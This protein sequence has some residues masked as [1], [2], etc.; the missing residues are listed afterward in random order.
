MRKQ[1]IHLFAYSCDDC[2]GPVVSASLAIR[3]NAISRETDIRQVGAICLS[4]GHRQQ[5]A[6]AT[7]AVRHFPPMEWEPADATG[8]AS[9]TTAL[10]EA[11]GRVEPR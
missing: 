10:V 4:C 2:H 8:R 5:N 7:A 1:Y 6:A 3:E 11:L 9:Q